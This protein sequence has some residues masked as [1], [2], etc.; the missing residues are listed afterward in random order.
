MASR[1]LTPNLYTNETLPTSKILLWRNTSGHNIFAAW[2]L[3][4]KSSTHGA[5]G[6]PCVGCLKDM[7]L[8]HHHPTTPPWHLLPDLQMLL[9][10]TAL[11]SAHLDLGY[12]LK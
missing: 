6:T 12:F 1:N 5:V 4:D 11:A 3:P 9:G 2:V 8:R 7:S 10:P